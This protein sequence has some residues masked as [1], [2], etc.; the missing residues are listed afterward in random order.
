MASERK[1]AASDAIEGHFALLHPTNYIRACEL[2]GRDVT[3]TIDHL[4]WEV[5]QCQ[6]GR[7]ERKPVVYMRS[8]K[9][10]LLEKRWVI[11]KTN[12][13]TIGALLGEPNVAKWKGRAITIFPTTCRGAD[14]GQVEC[15]RV[16]ARAAAL[17]EEPTDD[18]MAPVV[19]ASDFVSDA[20]D[21]DEVKARQVA[22][23]AA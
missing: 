12:L 5:L 16:R 20:E 10:A 22:T 11:N 17:K 18:M 21:A 19:P 14:G 23:G 7:K 6:G 8:A 13:R 2:R 3:I 1:A 15:I 4:A 9:G